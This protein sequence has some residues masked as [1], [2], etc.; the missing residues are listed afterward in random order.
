MRKVL[1]IEGM[2]CGHCASHVAR[3]LNAIP[4]V[5]AQVDLARKTATVESAEPVTDDV[6]R[7]AVQNAGYEVVA[8]HE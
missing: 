2:S 4:G 6:L 8:I 1:V 3:A 5:R 7:Q